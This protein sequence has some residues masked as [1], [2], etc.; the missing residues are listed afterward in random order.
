[1]DIA[2]TRKRLNNLL[3]RLLK[4]R[5]QNVSNK[6]FLMLVSIVVGFICGL[7]AVILKISV[8]GIQNYLQYEVDFPYHTTL[9]IVFP[10]IGILLTVIFVKRFLKKGLGRGL[11]PILY[12]IARNRS[13]VP[14]H[15]SW[16]HLSTSAITAGFGGS[17]GLEAPIVVT[18]SAIGSNIG[19]LLRMNYS[20]R[21]LLLGCGA[22]AGISAVFNCPIAGVIFALEVL[23]EGFSVSS[24]IPLLLS[25]ATAAVISGIFYTDQLFYLITTEWTVSRLP[26][27]TI[28]GIMCGLISAYMTR[29]TLRIEE[30]FNKSTNTYKKALFGG[31]S[32]GALIFLLPPLYGEGYSTIQELLNGNYPHLLRNSLME[33]IKVSWYLLAGFGVVIVIMKVV[34]ASLTIASGGNGGIFAPSLFTGGILGFSFSNTVN[35]INWINLPVSNFIAAGMAGILSGVVHAPLTAIFLIAEITGGYSLFVPL[36]IVSATSYFISRLFEPYSVYTTKLAK[37]GIW[38]QQNR[39]ASVLASMQLKTY[40]RPNIEWIHPDMSLGQMV[41]LV[42]HSP[43][44]LF[45]VVEE[46]G[47]LIG[48][49]K[50]E[51][52]REIL[53]KTELYEHTLVRTFMKIAEPVALMDESMQNIVEKFEASGANELPVTE[54]GLFRGFVAKSDILAGYRN[55]LIRQTKELS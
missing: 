14:S 11:S 35:Q 19:L 40:V 47:I 21:T 26:F 3:F 10:L 9:Y 38:S 50:V 5:M 42:T 55:H 6:N 17:A 15:K 43:R 28:L 27:Y 16:S 32:L 12:D 31:L 23:L 41:A 51:D 54:N 18:G 24:F 4:W 37:Q 49:V 1:M 7:A 36:M 34:A 30:R 45:P 25:S 33:N 44:D 52:L 46:N 29:T 2:E 20:E 48:L 53:F 39:D 8:Q 13:K 22:A